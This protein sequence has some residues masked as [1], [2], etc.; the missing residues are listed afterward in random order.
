[1]LHDAGNLTAG[2]SESTKT[3]HSVVQIANVRVATEVPFRA[4]S[5]TSL[6]IVISSLYLFRSREL[7][8]DCSPLLPLSSLYQWAVRH[9]R[10]DSH[11]LLSLS[12]GATPRKKR[13]R[14]TKPLSPSLDCARL[15]SLTSKEIG[16]GLFIWMDEVVSE[17][18][19]DRYMGQVQTESRME[20]METSLKEMKWEIKHE[21][22]LLR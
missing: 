5:P 4:N 18:T 6:P 14:L 15:K 19:P 13:P 20:E 7:S 16:C 22:Q 11:L 10:C 21:I 1:M 8:D 2:G 3:E 17:Y 12:P 9:L